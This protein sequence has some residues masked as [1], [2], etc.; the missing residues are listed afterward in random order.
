[1]QTALAES[2]YEILE[3]R[4]PPDAQAIAGAYRDSIHVLVTDADIPGVSGAELAERLTGLYPDLKV[5][6][7]T[8]YRHDDVQRP[9]YSLNAA[10]LA[11]PFPPFELLRAVELLLNAPG[12]APVQ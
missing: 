11:K 4:T 7:I 6:F 12:P 3:V 5:L 2:G 9:A 1:M 10:E 8:G